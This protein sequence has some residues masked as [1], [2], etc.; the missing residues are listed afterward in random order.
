MARY[1]IKAGSHTD[2]TTGKR[3]T[4]GQVFESD[5][6]FA[7]AF[8]GK[9]ELTEAA[10]TQNV[11]EA[12]GRLPGPNTARNAAAGPSTAQTHGHL[13][14]AAQGR[15]EDDTV[16][17]R[18]AKEAAQGSQTPAGEDELGEDVSAK[19]EGEVPEGH[20]V[21]KDGRKYFVVES[22]V[23]DRALNTEDITTQEA[24]REFLA[25]LKK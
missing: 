4:K 3:Y 6:D 25:G 19:F 2:R 13:S 24:V 20:K 18:A 22:T 17:G 5:K 7:A 23:P 8:P 12:P 15:P 16:A 11:G 1:M 21:L 10:V 9:F 14:G